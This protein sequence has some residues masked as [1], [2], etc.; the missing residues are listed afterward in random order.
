MQ[1][2]KASAGSLIHSQFP[3]QQSPIAHRHITGPADNSVGAG[4]MVGRQLRTESLGAQ[5]WGH[6]YVGHTRRMEREH[7]RGFTGPG[8]SPN[9]ASI[10][11]LN[12]PR[13][14]AKTA[15]QLGATLKL[16]G[17][18]L[19]AICVGM[20]SQPRAQGILPSLVLS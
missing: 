7:R 20:A 13:E 16:R 15:C 19:E 9:V 12:C 11:S 3:S 4:E 2:G 1:E 6:C 5:I 14:T 17:L 8:A 10:K 18:T